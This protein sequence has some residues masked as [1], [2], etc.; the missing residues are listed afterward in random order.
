MKSKEKTGYSSFFKLFA[1]CVSSLV[2]SLIL[3][4]SLPAY[5]QTPQTDFMSENYNLIE[6]YSSKI[7]TSVNSYG[8]LDTSEGKSVSISVNEKINVCRTALYDIQSHPE[9]SSRLL[10]AEIK[11]AYSRA[12]AIG[13][14]AWIY[15]YNIPTISDPNAVTRISEKYS[16]YEKELSNGSDS[17]LI[18]AQANVICTEF[19]RAVYSE[20][21]KGLATQNDSIDTA[22][23]IS[24]A[25]NSL[26]KISSP[27]L[28]GENFKKI[29]DKA[30]ADVGLQRTRDNVIYELSELFGVLFPKEPFNTNEAATL[31]IYNVKN[32]QTIPQVNKALSDAMLQ[33]TQP[34][35]KGN[36]SAIY[37]GNLNEKVA[38]ASNRA[39]SEGVGTSILNI[40]ENY[41]LD[42][43]KALSK[44]SINALIFAEIEEENDTLTKIELAFNASGGSVD[45]CQSISALS[46]EIKCAEYIRLVFNEISS[47]SQKLSVFLGSYDASVF[48]ERLKTIQSNT[49]ATLFEKKN[50]QTNFEAEC[51]TILQN[52]KSSISA[53]LNESRVERFLLDH[54]Q[55]LQK[56]KESIKEADELALRSAIT[57]YIK[58]DPSIQ[59]S[60]KSQIEGIAE[61][62]NILTCQKIRAMLSDDSFYLDLSE[63]LQT[64]AKN[65]SAENIEV[66]YNSC[67][68]IYAKSEVLRDI[69]LYYRQ[70]TSTENYSG[71]NDSEK[72]ELL[73]LSQKSAE[74]LGAINPADPLDF[75]EKIQDILQSSTLGM[76]RINECARVRISA[77]NSQ[78][79]AVQALVAEAGAKIKTSNSKNDMMAIS[80]KTIF[81][82]NRELTKEAATKKSDELKCLNF[83]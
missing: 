35:I 56:S 20:K 36:Y 12:E 45:R 80:D 9:V 11:A 62:Y 65:L 77:R 8:E 5:A 1:I 78:S 19:N 32:A 48:E 64:E 41:S 79:P 63:I 60:L 67:D 68:R 14:V 54:K 69:I 70:I 66:F 27:D 22:A 16:F 26:E 73:N 59:S 82:I 10:E 7:S 17:A 76:D 61:K 37:I 49:F 28:F 53:T 47:A 34:K 42:Y 46:L 38:D 74:N 21:I 2:A 51:K 30:S 55:I 57:E 75:Q 44:D 81:K 29:F 6:E 33:L 15:Y 43:Q 25:V 83:R 50:A 72:Q 3:G 52:A 58:L 4:I 13:R 23:L 71:F 31:F 24:G 39:S 40:F 18:D